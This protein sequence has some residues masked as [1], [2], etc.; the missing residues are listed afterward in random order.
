M[1]HFCQLTVLPILIWNWVPKN[2]QITALHNPD[3][4]GTGISHTPVGCCLH[5]STKLMP[6]ANR[7]SEFSKL[8]FLKLDGSPLYQISPCYQLV[9]CIPQAPLALFFEVDGGICSALAR[10]FPYT[11]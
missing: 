9:L 1:H 3:S 6:R 8:P 11:L 5:I 7:N 10:A 2:F 4:L